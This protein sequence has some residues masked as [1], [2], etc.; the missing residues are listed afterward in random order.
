MR[1]ISSSEEL[2]KKMVE[3]LA[4]AENAHAKIKTTF[5]INLLPE[6]NMENLH[7]IS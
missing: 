5:L 4:K 7:E 1:V 3:M 2:K 6:K